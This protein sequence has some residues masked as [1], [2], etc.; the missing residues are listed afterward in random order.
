MGLPDGVW[1]LRIAAATSFVSAQKHSDTMPL[2]RRGLWP[3]FL[4]FEHYMA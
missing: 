4:G 1:T 3:R 2:R